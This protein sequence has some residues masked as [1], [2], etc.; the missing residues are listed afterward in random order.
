MQK[1]VPLLWFK[2]QA[3]EALNLYVSIFKNSGAGR[4][5]RS[6]DAGPGPKGSVMTGTFTLDGGE[7]SAG[8]RA[9]ALVSTK[10]LLLPSLLVLPSRGY[11]R[12]PRLRLNG[13]GS[14]AGSASA[15]ETVLFR[16][17]VPRYCRRHGVPPA[18][19]LNESDGLGSNRIVSEYSPREYHVLRAPPW[20]S[21][22]KCEVRELRAR[23]AKS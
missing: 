17:S 12:G 3:E 23:C 9:I 5:V 14:C 20:I 7:F 6:D 16:G 11:G 10:S 1:S 22:A 2:D 21:R 19:A 15:A 18:V 13:Q 8:W 4:M